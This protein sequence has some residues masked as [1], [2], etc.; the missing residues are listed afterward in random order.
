[1]KLSSRSKLLKKILYFLSPFILVILYFFTGFLIDKNDF[2]G[3]TTTWT[4]L[5]A[6]LFF[7]V[8]LVLGTAYLA[9]RLIVKESAITI[10]FVE[11]IILLLLYL[12]LPF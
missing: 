1:M 2:Q 11:L 12:I 4:H 5:A 6:S 7:T 9:I 3:D 10:W 8:F